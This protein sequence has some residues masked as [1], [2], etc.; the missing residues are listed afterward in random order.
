MPRTS[1]PTPS[2]L[3]GH[4]PERIDDPGRPVD[5]HR[6]ADAD[7]GVVAASIARRRRRGRIVARILVGIMLLATASV[8][9]VE[10]RHTDV[11]STFAHIRWAYVGLGVVSIAASVIAAAYNLLGFTPLRLRLAPTLLAQLAVS[12]IRV[13]TPSAVSTPAIATRYLTQSG[14]TTS[15]A[16]ASVGVAQTVQLVVTIGLVGGCGV[17]SGWDDWHSV[18][19]LQLSL[20][21]TG[22]MLVFLVGWLVVRWNARAARFARQASASVM[23]VVAHT[24]AHPLSALTGIVA[25]AMLTVTHIAAF[26]FCVHAAGGQ[27]SI[28][29]LSTVYLA[30]AAAGSIFPTPGG[31]GAVEAALIA[32][33]TVAG[34]PL[35]AATAATLLSRLVSVWLLV[36]PG[37]IALIGLRRRGLL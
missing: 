33:L 28:L 12:A 6:Q 20:W 23:S 5:A 29:T 15:D 31:T 1:T 26:A 24:R 4:T 2:D 30:S 32:G 10:L 27:A 18:G 13:V 11:R 19:R 37:W 34:V 21:L 17:V 8:L 36:P 16:L 14:A 3:I 35:P 7:I 9:F 22:G 25:G